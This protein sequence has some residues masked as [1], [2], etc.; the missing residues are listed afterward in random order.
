[1]SPVK[2]LDVLLEII[3]QLVDQL[4]KTHAGDEEA[5]EG[6]EVWLNDLTLLAS[7]HHHAT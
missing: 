2:V 3:F 5:G 1:M 7:F 6:R 4:S